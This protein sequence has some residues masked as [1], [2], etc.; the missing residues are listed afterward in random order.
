MT[1]YIETVK[2]QFRDRK[3]A[4][5]V[6]IFTVTRLIY[7]WAWVE[8]ASHKLAWFSDGKLNSA[9]KIETLITNIAGPKVTNFDPLYINK[10]FS[11]LAQ[12]IFLSMPGVTDTLV[13][14]F[15]LLVG[16]SMLLGFRIFWF[17]LL[18]MFMNVQF[19]AGGSFNNF[20]Y[21]WTNLA[22]LKFAPYAELLGVGG[23]LKYKQNKE[24]LSQSKELSTT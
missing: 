5:L 24:L 18:A 3:V 20:G 8:S 12:N 4:L 13:V 22:F 9:G 15:E 1:S 19:L 11:W 10:G 17:A 16:L 23:F 21:I 14:I 2:T 7:G 6:I